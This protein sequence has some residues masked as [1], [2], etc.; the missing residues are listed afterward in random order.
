MGANVAV[1]LGAG[2]GVLVGSGA[3]V[4]VGRGVG[5]GVRA[6]PGGAAIVVGEGLATRSDIGAGVVTRVEAGTNLTTTVWL[7]SIV[8]FALSSTTSNTGP[9]HLSICQP[10]W[11]K[12]SMVTVRPWTNKP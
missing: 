10:G 1:N 7:E 9:T 6:V 12:T 4:S 5:A 11:S 2:L 3:T 8:I